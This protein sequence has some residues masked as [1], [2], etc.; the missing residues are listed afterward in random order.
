[1][2][3]LCKDLKDQT[4]KI[5]NYEK[6]DMIRLT[7]KEKKSQEKQ[8]ICYICKKE[9]CT[10]K[11]NEKEFKLYHEVRDHCHYTRKYRGAA[12]S[13]CNLCYKIP[14]ET[15]VV[16]H[17]DSTYDYHFIIRQLVKEFKGNFDCLG[18]NTEKYITFSVPIKKE[19]DNGKTITYKLKFIDSCRF[20]ITSLSSL[21][22]NLSEINKKECKSCMKRN[23]II[24]E[25][26]YISFENNRLTYKCK[27]CSD[28]SY[29][30]IKGLIEKFPNTY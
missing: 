4:I 25:C 15:P 13:I 2:E 21:V 9:F 3:K 22:Y 8:R 28:K 24:S 11:N 1:M 19:L 14:K 12:H 23:S 7:N 17:D 16:F 29:K 26:K 10:N 27:K 20:L 30:S 5:I 18:E 6:K